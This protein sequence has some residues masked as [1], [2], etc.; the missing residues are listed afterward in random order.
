MKRLI[1]IPFLFFAT[2]SFA[3]ETAINLTPHQKESI[4]KV[5]GTE[6][7]STEETKKENLLQIFMIMLMK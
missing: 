3:Q 4:K 2:F 5:I 6:E 1:F 7:V